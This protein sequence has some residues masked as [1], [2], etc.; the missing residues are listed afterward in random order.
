MAIAVNAAIIAHAA[1][2]KMLSVKTVHVAIA[3]NATT[4]THAA[5]VAHA[6]TRKI[7]AA[8]IVHAAKT[9]HN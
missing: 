5:I 1:T 7:L 2:K 3:V 4:I 9:V 8:K 6:S